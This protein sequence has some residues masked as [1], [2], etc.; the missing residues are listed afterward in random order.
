MYTCSIFMER[1]REIEFY[2]DFAI[3]VAQLDLENK[4]TN[5]FL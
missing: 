1:R 2:S 3:R 4:Y 5:K